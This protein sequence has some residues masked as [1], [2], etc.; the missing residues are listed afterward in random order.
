MY[1]LNLVRKFRALG[2]KL[3]KQFALLRKRQHRNSDEE[4]EDVDRYQ[5]FI[6]DDEIQYSISTIEQPTQVQISIDESRTKLEVLQRRGSQLH[7]M[8]ERYI[9][10][11]SAYI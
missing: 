11:L 10:F 1:K 2:S 4:S 3:K 7:T 9:S 8:R 6:D 5:N